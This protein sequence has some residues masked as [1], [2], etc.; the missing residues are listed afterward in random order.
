[1]GEAS[2][3]MGKTTE[4]LFVERHKKSIEISDFHCIFCH[5]AQKARRQSA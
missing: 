4:R 5:I 3:D 1:M 2:Q